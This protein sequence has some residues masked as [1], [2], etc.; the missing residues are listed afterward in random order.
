MKKIITAVLAAAMLAAPAAMAEEDNVSVIVNN[1]KVE[2]DQPPII[3]EGHTL[4]PIRAVFEKAGAEVEWNQETQTATLTKGNYTVNI[5]LNDEVLYKNGTP[6][7][8]AMPAKIVNDRV[9]I[10]VRAIG[11]AMDFKIEW[12]G[13]HS[14]VV[15]STD[16]THYRP[17]AARR[18][19]FRELAEAAI[20]Y[21]TGSFT[22]QQMDVDND[23]SM[24]TVS[25][26]SALDTSSV[27]TPLLMINGENFTEQLAGMPSIYSFALV[28]TNAGDKS[29]EIIITE[30]GDGFTAHFYRLD[31]KSLV[32]I[33]TS[34]G[35]DI[36]IKY[37]SK[38]FFDN[39]AFI[40]SDKDG[41]TWT[42][43][44]FTISVFKYDSGSLNHIYASNA[45]KIV[46]RKLLHAY[47]DTMAY[48]VFR[49]D[50]FKPGTYIN[51]DASEILNAADFTDF[52]LEAVYAD[53]DNPCLIELFVTLGDGTKM[54]LVPYSS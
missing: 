38:L 18:T 35:N 48:K 49:T 11:E 32:P 5:T 22:W 50:E 2:F 29:R 37:A 45:E 21:S 44:M 25:F 36:S 26:T 4:V 12:D 34:T 7:A 33:K 43:I 14:Q 16:G 27:E 3:D 40:L 30:N 1:E 6:V 54:V 15:V 42:D 28:D 8:L 13:F 17:Y 53:S 47:N 19:A 41:L 24:D 46:P 51:K 23:G 31:G 10:P 39:D 20:Y 9:L 52:T